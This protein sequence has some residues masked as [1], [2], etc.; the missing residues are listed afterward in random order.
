MQRGGGSRSCRQGRSMTPAP[1]RSWQGSA[2][3]SSRRPSC[4]P[5]RVP[6]RLVDGDTTPTK[7]KELPVAAPA[8]AQMQLKE[9]HAHC[10]L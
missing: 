5:R 10:L 7:C 9:I 3:C 2:R 6:T 8:I 4:A 1:S